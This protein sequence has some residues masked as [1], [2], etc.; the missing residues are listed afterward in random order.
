MGEASREWAAKLDG[1]WAEIARISADARTF[2]RLR[3]NRIADSWDNSVYLFVGAARIRRPWVRE[4]VAR[5]GMAYLDWRT[6][7]SEYQHLTPEVVAEL[8]AKFDLVGAEVSELTIERSKGRLECRMSV[9]VERTEVSYALPDIH[10]Y[11]AGVEALRFDADDRF[12][13]EFSWQDGVPVISVGGEGVVRASDVTLWVHHKAWAWSPPS[14]PPAS[15]EPSRWRLGRSALHGAALEAAT[16]LHDA[17]LLTRGVWALTMTHLVPVRAFGRVFAGAGTD[18]LAAGSAVRRDA[19]FR[20]LIGQ[21]RAA[22]GAE[23]APW[24]EEPLGHLTPEPP[25]GPAPQLMLAGFEVHHPTATLLYA[26]PG[27]P[28]TLRRVA[29]ERPSRFTVDAVAFEHPRAEA[30]RRGLVRIEAE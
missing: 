14:L 5:D 7:E 6:R 27:T 22:G 20:G 28:W 1:A 3:L 30:D 25:A 21:W 2:D 23:L 16:L 29:V 10:L 4:A 19:A 12:G 15:A 9:V 18:I 24:F 13:I 17:L 26:T 8:A 11:C